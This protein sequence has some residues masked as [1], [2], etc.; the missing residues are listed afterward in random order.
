[1]NNVTKEHLKTKGI[2][3]IYD[4]Q[5]HVE[6]IEKDFWYSKFKI[7]QQWKF[8]NWRE[9]QTKGYVELYTGFRCTSKLGFNQVNN[10]AIQGTAFHAALKTLI[11]LNKFLRKEKFNTVILGEI[12]DSIVLDLDPLELPFIV[13]QVKKIISDIKEEWC[14]LIV[15]L[16]VDFE[17][18]GINESWDKKKELKI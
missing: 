16:K 13:R 12:H 4:F 3:N 5:K 2:D 14:W 15:P 11:E 9:Y 10:I 7:Y 18:T 8:D 1:M 17:I 6:N